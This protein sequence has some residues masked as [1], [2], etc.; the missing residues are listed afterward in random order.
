MNAMEEWAQRSTM[1][2][3][4]ELE[5]TPAETFESVELSKEIMRWKQVAKHMDARVMEAEGI[6]ED[7]K[8]EKKEA[9]DRLA[10]LMQKL[11]GQK[12]RKVEEMGEAGAVIIPYALPPSKP[13]DCPSSAQ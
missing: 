1:T 4:V 7:A 9:E 5:K 6:L 8:S 11:E 2:A 13:S 3:T 12:K 10:F